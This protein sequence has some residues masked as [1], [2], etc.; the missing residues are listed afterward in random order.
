MC[1]GTSLEALFT[2]QGYE[3]CGPVV[4]LADLVD[5]SGGIAPASEV[6]NMLLVGLVVF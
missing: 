4:V 1:F 3:V 6:E 5:F 2:N